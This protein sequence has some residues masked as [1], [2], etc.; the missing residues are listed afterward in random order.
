MTDEDK[1]RLSKANLDEDLLRD[2]DG[3]IHHI[4]EIE[5]I[6]KDVLKH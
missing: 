1:E 6:I 3:T 2:K 4:D 5:Y